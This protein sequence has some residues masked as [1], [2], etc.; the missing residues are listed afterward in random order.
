MAWE[1]NSDSYIQNGYVWWTI[2]PGFVSAA[3]VYNGVVHSILD[4][5][6]VNYTSGSSG[7]V[8]PSIALKRDV[9]I[10]SG[11]GSSNNPFVILTK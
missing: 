2:S 1:G 4:H 3:G 11:D 7:G 6:A 8:R 10:K 5:V 9:I